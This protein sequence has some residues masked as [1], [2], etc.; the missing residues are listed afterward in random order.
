MGVA[1]S[2]SQSVGDSMEGSFLGKQKAPATVITRAME[3]VVMMVLATGLVIG[4]EDWVFIE[5][6]S[7][8][9]RSDQLTNDR[10]RSLL[11]LI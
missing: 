10:T 7:P 6:A 9:V 3:W 1:V 2:A 11:L 8:H 5:M 4:A